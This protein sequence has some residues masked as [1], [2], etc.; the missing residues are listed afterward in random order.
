MAR[1]DVTGF[2]LLAV[3]ISATAE[4][5]I[6]RA[7]L[8]S[9][10]E[11]RMARSPISGAVVQIQEA[12]NSSKNSKPYN[13]SYYGVLNPGGPD[14]DHNSSPATNL[15]STASSYGDP[16]HDNIK[17]AREAT[18]SSAT[19]LNS[20]SSSYGDPDHDNIK[21]AREVTNS[22]ATNLLISSDSMLISYVIVLVVTL[23]LQQ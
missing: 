5:Q 23:L 1:L 4:T 22:S 3:F 11:S 12:E 15:N 14:P 2:L 19:N 9:Q 21:R 10:N 13:F 7:S 6:V 20:T 16:D 17:R 18:N 8:G